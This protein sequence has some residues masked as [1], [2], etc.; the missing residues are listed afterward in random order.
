MTTLLVERAPDLRPRAADGDGAT[1]DDLL[2]GAWEGLAAACST[3]CPVCA[4]ELESRWSTG[5]TLAGGRCRDCASE[6]R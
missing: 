1:L 5:A 2:S 4:G 3:T 6:L